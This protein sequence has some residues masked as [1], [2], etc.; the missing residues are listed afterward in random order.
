MK[1]DLQCFSFLPKGFVC[2]DSVVT[3]NTKVSFAARGVDCSSDESSKLWENAFDPSYH[4]NGKKCAGYVLVPSSINCTVQ[5]FSDT[6]I[7]RLCNCVSSGKCVNFH[8]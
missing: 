7:R 5:G 2:S 4:V 3:G 8:Y 1:I 6:N